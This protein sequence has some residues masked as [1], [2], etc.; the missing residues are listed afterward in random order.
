M[1]A[2]SDMQFNLLN[3]VRLIEFSIRI[4]L[5]TYNATRTLKVLHTHPIY[6]TNGRLL[7]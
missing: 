5:I 3:I 1:P 6:R 7:S 4:V 2:A